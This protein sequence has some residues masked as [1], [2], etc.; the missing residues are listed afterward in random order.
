MDQSKKT[1]VKKKMVCKS[2]TSFTYN[3]KDLSVYLIS[4]YFC[5]HLNGGPPLLTSPAEKIQILSSRPVP[6]PPQPGSRT[7]GSAPSR[8]RKHNLSAFKTFGTKVVHSKSSQRL[9]DQ[10]TSK[11]LRREFKCRHI[12]HGTETCREN[13]MGLQCGTSCHDHIAK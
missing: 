4:V 11:C 2:F 3:S 12:L 7:T 13:L 9:S 5:M 1:Q 10:T 6:S 8:C